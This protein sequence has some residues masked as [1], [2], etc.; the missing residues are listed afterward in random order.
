MDKE[1]IFLQKKRKGPDNNNEDIED[2]ND[3]IEKEKVIIEEDLKKK[4]GFSENENVMVEEDMLEK[5]N[6]L[7]K[8]KETNE[9][10]LSLKE[11]KSNQIKTEK[12]NENEL[13]ISKNT[14]KSEKSNEK[15]R[16]PRI[17][18]GEMSRDEIIIKE[19]KA[20][21]KGKKPINDLLVKG[22]EAFTKKK[23]YDFF[24]FALIKHISFLTD[25]FRDFK[26]DFTYYIYN[27]LR[28][29]M[30]SKEFN[31]NLKLI[32]YKKENDGF[33]R[34]FLNFSNKRWY[35][36]KDAAEKYDILLKNDYIKSYLSN[37]E[38]KN[39]N[40]KENKNNTENALNNNNNNN[41][42]SLSNQNNKNSNTQQ[43]NNNITSNSEN[44]NNSKE[45]T[46]QGNNNEVNNNTDKKTE[47]KENEN[48][49]T[50]EPEPEKF[51]QNKTI[52]IYRK[53]PEENQ[54]E[55]IVAGMVY[56]SLLKNEKDLP[57]EAKS[58]EKDKNSIAPTVPVKIEIQN[59]NIQE[60]PM[61]SV[62]S[63]I[64]FYTNI[65]EINLS[66]NSLTPK[67]CFWLGSTVKTN[68][69]LSMI[70]ISR[71]N[72]NND[73]LYM[74]VEGT[75]FSDENLNK[76]QFNLER[77][78]LKDNNHI[79]G[80][81]KNNYEHPLCLIL[82][83]FKLR[84]INL[85]NAKI[86]GEGA[87]KFVGKMGEL[88]DKNKLFLENLILICNEFKNES[89]LTKL[90]EIILKEN[91][92]LKNLILSKNLISTPTMSNQPVNHFKNFMESVGK[93][94]IKELFLI[95]C[96]IGTIEDDINILYD[97]LRINK[98]L[99][100]IRL[101]GNKISN[102]ASFTKILGIFSDFNENKTLA[103]NTLKSLD[104]SKNSCDIKVTDNFMQL[105]EHL[106]L[107]YLD[108]NQ[109][110]MDKKD[111]EI[112]RKGTNDLTNIKIIY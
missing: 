15:Q 108:I 13:N 78:N 70:D 104:L 112:F 24:L 40:S 99:V 23:E 98:S 50:K 29:L 106:K 12:Q 84:W 79:V 56:N 73:C 9:E 31:E 27:N 21:P 46:P 64:K 60:I 22:F 61:I 47:N 18:K 109:N 67:G 14:F 36:F 91:C 72:I 81:V 37:L 8:G 55:L 51:D 32:S 105:I 38:E 82:E 68:P 48:N 100:S 11:E 65:I 16:K 63:G 54:I 58:I 75:N 111:K 96:E 80:T 5:K 49:K 62:I 107:E 57:K 2:K 86:R 93:S 88:L 90:G 94:K 66:G 33:F 69:N 41:N 89:C 103:N 59:F 26:E 43:I 53:F 20:I 35:K 71:C 45:N 83:K 4:E 92:P 102:L 97:M 25:N 10:E 34:E 101:F 95:S 42:N 85:T 44:A 52:E 76:E 7:E 17:K 74:F 39:N 30:L 110:N 87:L 28:V 77:L 3:Y 19:I 1:I 6:I